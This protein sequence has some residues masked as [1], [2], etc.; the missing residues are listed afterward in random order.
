[1][2]NTYNFRTFTPVMIDE[3]MFALLRDQ[4]STAQAEKGA[5]YTQITSLTAEIRMLRDENKRSRTEDNALVRQLQ[6]ALSSVQS[7]LDAS[8]S[9]LEKKD[10]LISILNQELAKER[11]RNA[12]NNRKTFV[13][14]S[15][16]ARLL[17]NRNVD[18]R[19]HEKADF[20]GDSV[21]GSKDDTSTEPPSE[22]TKKE[23]R[24]RGRKNKSEDK[25]VKETITHKLAD[26]H[27]LPK[28]GRY[29]TRKGE[30]ETYFYEYTEYHPARVVR[31]I[32]EVARVAM[33]D[34]E[35]I[36]SS[37]PEELRKAAAKGCPFDAKMLAF[38]L[39]E[40]YAYHS[41]INTV[42]KKLR[43]MGAVFS[44]TTLNRYYH[45]GVEALRDCFDSTLKREIHGSNYLMIDETCELVGVKND[46]G[47]VS[48]KKKYLW[49]F[50]DKA[51]KLVHYIY[52]KGSRG[53][54]VVEDY[55]K[56]WKGSISTDG[57]AAYKA[58]SKKY[59]WILHIGC[60]AHTRR[61][62][63]ESLISDRFNSMAV[64][65][66][67]GELFDIEYYC[68]LLNM[69]TDDRKQERQKKSRPILAKIYM[70]VRRMS[71]SPEV[72]A[73]P[74]LAKAVK[75]TLNQ[76]DNLRNFI[77]DG[78]AEISNNLVE[79][80]MKPIKL[81]LKNSQNIGS[82]DAA[83]RHAFMHSL[84]E[85]CSMNKI[86]AYGYLV[87]LLDR[88]KTLTEEEKTAFMPCYYENNLKN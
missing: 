50:L 58:F 68:R 71:G 45:M 59:P 16:Q 77:L 10:E 63:I 38:I 64:I 31:H 14:T 8:L 88:Y 22:E 78:K 39:C 12:N 9:L 35:T 7:K 47:E 29:L 83:K 21:G 69:S 51:K 85:S 15:E 87:N 55:L 46:K 4:L 18:E 26:Y 65:E 5:L 19:S 86:A 67:I 61:L 17:N 23:K 11:D 30:I 79:Q 73:N 81:D 6:S 43:D 66:A 49:A 25:F 32:Y 75:Y 48:Y 57:Y 53:L 28:G 41:P 76:W 74:T 56:D 52:E 54:S 13:R 1:M 3:R 40:K 36:V 80:R 37:L 70:M 82:E 2:C 72:M 62:Y 27:I 34:G 84:I 60:W 44:K 20:D 24:P 33:P 42:K